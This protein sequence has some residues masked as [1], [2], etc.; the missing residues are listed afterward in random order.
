MRCARMLQHPDGIVYRLEAVRKTLAAP[1]IKN[2]QNLRNYR[3]SNL[4]RSFCA[5]VEADR[6]PEEIAL[7]FVLVEIF[8][9]PV[10]TASWP[11]NSKVRCRGVEQEG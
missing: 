6:S 10:R 3:K 4:F 11:Q 7:Q 8:Q 9:H 2:R 5:Q 1:S